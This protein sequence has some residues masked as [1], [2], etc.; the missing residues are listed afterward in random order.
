MIAL[1][2]PAHRRRSRRPSLL[3]SPAAKEEVDPRREA[4]RPNLP[5]PRLVRTRLY[6]AVTI[7]FVMPWRRRSIFASALKSA[8]RN[9]TSVS[10]AMLVAHGANAAGVGEDCAS[11][12]D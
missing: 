11:E 4:R 12:S 8:A 3:Q 6:W 1:L 9:V 5:S 7:L 10:L 2:P